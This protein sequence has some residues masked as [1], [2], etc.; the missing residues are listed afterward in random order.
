M[1][2]PKTALTICVAICAVLGAVKY[3]T[4]R[5][6]RRLDGFCEAQSL[7]VPRRTLWMQ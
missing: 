3:L 7:P 1:W 2:D 5:L 4:Y 6:V